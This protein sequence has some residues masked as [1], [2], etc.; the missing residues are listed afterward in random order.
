VEAIA[1]QAEVQ[2]ATV[3]EAATE[4]VILQVAAVRVAPEAH[5]LLHLVAAGADAANMNT[6]GSIENKII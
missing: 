3:E 2:E 4:A 1:L 6:I 5:H